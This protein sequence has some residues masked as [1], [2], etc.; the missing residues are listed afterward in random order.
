MPEG[1]HKGWEF[2]TCQLRGHFLGHWLSA[3]AMHYQE[4]GDEQIRAKADAIVAE[5]A[6]CQTENGGRWVGP[7]PEK[8]LY[9]IAAGKQVWAPHYT[10][11]KVFMGLLDMYSLAGS[12][13]ALQIAERFADWFYEWSGKYSREEFDDILDFETGGMLEIWAQLYGITGNPRYRELMERYYRGR[14]VDAD[15]YKRQLLSMG[16]PSYG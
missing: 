12:E 4:T 1:I 10:I 7:I 5:L 9:R 11:H 2:P 13:L 14:L 6:E 3:A 15:G 16:V 8:Y